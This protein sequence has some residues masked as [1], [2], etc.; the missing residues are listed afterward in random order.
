MSGD[1][2]A[3]RVYFR[4]NLFFFVSPS[5]SFAVEFTKAA[6]IYR[7]YIYMYVCACE[8]DG[9][10][11]MSR[12]ILLFWGKQKK[13]PFN[14][15]LRCRCFGTIAGKR[16]GEIFHL[17]N[18]VRLLFTHFLRCSRRDR[19]QDRG[20]AWFYAGEWISRGRIIETLC[21]ICFYIGFVAFF[22]L[23]GVPFFLVFDEFSVVDHFFAINFGLLFTHFEIWVAQWEKGE[24]GNANK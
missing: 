23:L 22:A 4:R 16:F 5:L 7:V 8:K 18:G 19:W 20:R 13:S 1:G 12:F 6:I 21:F 15:T 3:F 24:S 2:K 11:K 17:E 14:S 10:Y 9:L